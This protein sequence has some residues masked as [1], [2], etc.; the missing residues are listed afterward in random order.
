MESPGYTH[1]PV[2]YQMPAFYLKKDSRGHVIDDK[3][4]LTWT[5]ESHSLA[6]FLLWQRYHGGSHEGTDTI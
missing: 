1:P 2:Q 6:F 4:F 3:V 5:S